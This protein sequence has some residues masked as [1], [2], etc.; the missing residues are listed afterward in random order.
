M[1]GGSI[2][3]KSEIGTNSTVSGKAYGIYN[4][5]YCGTGIT[6]NDTMITATSAL[7]ESYGIYNNNGTVVTIGEKDEN[8]R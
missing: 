3:A 8:K 5:L 7:N 2:S 1:E 4:N 6:G